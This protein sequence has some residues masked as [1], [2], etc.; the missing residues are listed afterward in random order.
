MPFPKPVMVQRVPEMDCTR[1]RFDDD[2]VGD[3][4]VRGGICWPSVV[5]TGERME[6]KGHAVL[7][8]VNIR[9]GRANVF[10]SEPFNVVSAEVRDGRTTARPLGPVL[11]RWWSSWLA[12]TYYW[13][14]RGETHRQFRLQ[15]VR[16]EQIMPKPRLVNIEWD[17]DAAAEQVFWAAAMGKSMAMDRDVFDAVSL[18]PMGEW[19]PARHA[20]IC[21]L[22]GLQRRPWRLTEKRSDWER[23]DVSGVNLWKPAR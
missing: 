18:V 5:L 1:V 19:C 2:T 6:A 23:E 12:E 10:E 3:Y 20:L 11:N 16:D 9:T 21:V 13:R 17:D 4:Y 8:A 14:D 7:V 22:A 15:V